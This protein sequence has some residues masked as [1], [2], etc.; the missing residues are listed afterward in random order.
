[1]LSVE[2]VMIENIV[3]YSDFFPCIANT[4]THS[5]SANNCAILY[6]LL[7]ILTLISPYMFRRNR[8]HQ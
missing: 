4:I 6:C 1:M 5:I 3:D 2:E 7:Y 8:H